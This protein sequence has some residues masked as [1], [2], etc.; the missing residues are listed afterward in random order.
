M[1]KNS[2][3]KR[4]ARFFG[5]ALTIL[6][7]VCQTNIAHADFL[8]TPVEVEI[9][10]TV[11]GFVDSSMLTITGEDDAPMPSETT[12]VPDS[13]GNASYRITYNEPGTYVY[14]IVQSQKNSEVISAPVS[15]T[16][17]VFVKGSE[18]DENVLT[19][20]LLVFI[21]SSDTKPDSMVFVNVDKS[22]PNKTDEENK[23][24]NTQNNTDS[25]SKDKDKGD[26]TKDKDKDNTS[27]STN[28]KSS[29]TD[30]TNSGSSNKDTTS[31]SNEGKSSSISSVQTGDNSR[32]AIWIALALL[33]LTVL[34]ATTDASK[35]KR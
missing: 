20:S 6:I 8:Y 21:K 30:K 26:T 1:G 33:S 2:T 29:D 15:Y 25:D 32:I 23:D 7:A 24:D 16:A 5:C 3:Y 35:K 13:A 31:G 10:I 11:N 19:A 34:Y 28:K 22:G 9:P 18:A 27:S 4:I 14:E 12:L 17:K